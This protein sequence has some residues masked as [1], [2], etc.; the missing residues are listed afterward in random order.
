MSGYQEDMHMSHEFDSPTALGDG[1]IKLCGVYG[2]NDGA[3][4]STLVLTVNPDAGPSRPASL[5]P[6]PLSRFVVASDAR[7]LE[8]RTWRV[9][10]SE[11]AMACELRDPPDAASHAATVA[12]AL[13]PDVLHF[14]PG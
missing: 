12:D 4:P 6:D 13:L 2:F 3:D 10:L 14:R 7:V 8:D 5:R 9:T 1:R 11:R